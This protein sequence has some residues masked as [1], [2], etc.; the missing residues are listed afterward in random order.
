[1]EKLEKPNAKK[2]EEKDVQYS[3][4]S[5]E[6]NDSSID[7]ADDSLQS[8]FQYIE[9]LQKYFSNMIVRKS[10]A[11]SKVFAA[12]GLPSYIRDWLVMKFSDKNGVLDSSKATQYVSRI[13]PNKEQWNNMMIGLFKGETKRFLTKIKISFD[14]K[15]RLVLFELPDYEIPRH[16]GEAIADWN[17]VEKNKDYLLVNNEVWG[18]VSIS[19]ENMEKK[20]NVFK[21]V[22]F[23]PFCPYTLNLDYYCKARSYFTTEEWINVLI[24]AM[25]YNPDGYSSSEEK[26]AFLKRILPFV[27][28]RLNLIELAPKETGKSYVFSQISKHGWLVSGGS[29]TR[30]KLFYDINK[31][32]DGLVSEYDYIALDEIQSIS[33]DN[34]L[35]MQGIFKGYL[36]SGE[37]R[38]GTHYG[39][40]TAGM[41]LLGNIETSSMDVEKNMFVKLPLIFRES[42]LVDR[43]HGFIKGWEI[44]KMRE[45][46]KADNWALNTEY[47]SEILHL[48][49]NESRYRAVV[50]ELLILPKNAATRDTEAIKRLC[51]AYLK[52]LFPHVVSA[53]DVDKEEFFKYCLKPSMEM[54]GIIKTQLGLLDPGEFGGTVVPDIMVRD[55]NNGF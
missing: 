24:G 29:V 5:S 25:D 22:D 27:E 41:V 2:K 53:S 43:F 32:T 55:V 9:K 42:A 47:F 35:E 11:N 4:Q 44:P 40:G 38:V 8:N 31:K 15:N 51:A 12:L 46:M 28:K 6:K 7:L 39:T 34:T 49:R 14:T 17:V 21:L 26:C 33:F 3:L 52:L 19:I 13:I 10:V 30:A 23:T 20:G 1:M 36:E 16:K 37:Y 50:D 18:I 45:E 48:L 54:R